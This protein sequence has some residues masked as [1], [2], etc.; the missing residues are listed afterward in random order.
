[1]TNLEFFAKPTKFFNL[2]S[3][4]RGCWPKKRQPDQKRNFKN[5]LTNNK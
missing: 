4:E 1:M 2:V 3:Q 5:R